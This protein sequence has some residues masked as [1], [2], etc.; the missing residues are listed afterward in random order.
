M[1]LDAVIKRLNRQL[2]ITQTDR[3]AR[4]LQGRLLSYLEYSA[5]VA[6]GN[7]KGKLLRTWGP[8]RRVGDRFVSGIGDRGRLGNPDRSARNA[9]KNFL[10]DYPQ[11]RAGKSTTFRA[12]QAWWILSHEAKAVLQEQ[13]QLGKYGGAYQSIASGKAAYFYPQEGSQSQ[14]AESA[15]AAGITP[16]RFVERSVQ[17]WRDRDVVET[18]FEFMADITRA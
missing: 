15:A 12:A 16:Q 9:I 2:N 5:P 11:Y 3:Y 13:R 10:A 7:L 8:Q 4:Q 1:Y 14:W 6:T 17:I 18:L